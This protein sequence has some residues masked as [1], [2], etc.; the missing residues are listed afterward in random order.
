MLERKWN[1]R[2]GEKELLIGGLRRASKKKEGSSTMQMKSKCRVLTPHNGRR[3]GV[4]SPM[5]SQLLAFWGGDR[6]GLRNN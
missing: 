2:Y 4:S 5:P 3:K 6:D 1:L